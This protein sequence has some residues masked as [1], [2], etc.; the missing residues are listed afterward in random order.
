MAYP[1]YE[2]LL[3]EPRGRA[4]WLTLNRPEA[5]NTLSLQMAADLHDCLDRLYQDRDIHV[6]VLRGAGR[7]FCAGLDLK[8]TAAG[9]YKQAPFAGG[10]DLQSHL[11][12]IFLKLRRCPQPIIA[13]V[14][15]PACG[16]GFAMALASDIRIAGESA[17][18]STSTIRLG[19]SGC[20]MGMSW[21][22]PR[23]VGGSIASEL[24]LTARFIEAPRALATG[25]VSEVVPDSELEAA[26][27]GYL[28]DM[29]AGTPIGLRLTK[30]GINASLG[31]ASLEACIMLE[32]RNQILAGT[33]SDA[34]EARRAFVEKRKPIYGI[35]RDGRA[36]DASA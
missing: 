12:D 18:M 30:D 5:L 16:G 26:A 1:Q 15:G 6:V 10:F 4:L 32:N 23:I 27:Q 34:R 35:D 28:N 17:R 11:S 3:A 13:L 8:E 31:A 20:E 22:L 29:L 25:L 19:L 2:T 33:S 9:A 7:A 14:H 24:M 21:F 36:D